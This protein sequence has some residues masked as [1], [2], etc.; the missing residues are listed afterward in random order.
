M[1]ISDKVEELAFGV[2][3]TYKLYE[4]VVPSDC[5]VIFLH[6]AGE[7][8]P[9]DGSK[10]SLVEKHGYPKHAKAGYE[11]PFNIVALQTAT[12]HRNLVKIV[13]PYIKLK[14]HARAIIVTG[15]SLGGYGAYDAALYDTLGLIT[16][17]APVC[18]AGRISLV[19]E[20][21]KNM[22]VFHI[23]GDI[24]KTVKWNTAKGFIEK[25]NKTVSA[26][27]RYTLYHQVGHDA[28]TQAYSINPL[29]DDLLQWIIECFQSVPVVPVDEGYKERV[30]SAVKAVQ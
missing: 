3:I 15:L 23:H 9:V 2:K 1:N 5:F 20:Y 24:D 18:G 8:G 25:Y 13:V 27:I 26:T 4:A 22:K 10:L 14:Y 30:I 6:G 16:A 11:F 12:D 7:K 28:W 19:S 17:I 21:P 29:Q